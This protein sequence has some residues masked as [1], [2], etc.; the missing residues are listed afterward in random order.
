MKKFLNMST[1]FIDFQGF[2]VDDELVIK[3][4]CIMDAN[5]V[6]WP[7]HL[8]FR[9][10]LTW[11]S[12]SEK[13]Q[14]VNLYLMKNHHCL[15]WYEGGSYFCPTCILKAS[16]WSRGTCYVLNTSDSPNS[17]EGAKIKTLQQHFPGVRFIEYSKSADELPKVPDNISCP[18]RNHGKHCAYKHCLCMFVDYCKSC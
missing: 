5:D 12:I 16:D 10:L 2:V 3:E 18:Y 13:S 7:I 1:Y 17:I 9:D 15:R 14:E 4:L 11:E 6:F 8:V